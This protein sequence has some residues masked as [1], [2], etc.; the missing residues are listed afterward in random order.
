MFKI[1]VFAV[2]IQSK[3]SCLT[4]RRVR[5]L[6]RNLLT[7]RYSS[8]EKQTMNEM[9]RNRRCHEKFSLYHNNH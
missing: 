2:K 8:I 4:L 1:F 6:I 5:H 9:R 3:Y 7:E